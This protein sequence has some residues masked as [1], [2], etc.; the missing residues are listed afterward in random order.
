LQCIK[1]VSKKVYAVRNSKYN[2]SGQQ[3][4][5]F[6]SFPKDIHISQ[7]LVKFAN[8]SKLNDVMRTFGHLH[9]SLNYRI[10]LSHFK[11]ENFILNRIPNRKLLKYG[12]IPSCNS[13]VKSSPLEIPLLK[14]ASTSNLSKML[15]KDESKAEVLPMSFETTTVESQESIIQQLK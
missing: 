11:P 10:C 8:N 14:N 13:P 1:M 5:S 3:R 9:L 6:H 7:E 12:V 15:P 4:L 2:L